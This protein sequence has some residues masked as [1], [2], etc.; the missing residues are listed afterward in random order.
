MKLRHIRAGRELDAQLA[1]M[2]VLHIV[3]GQTLANFTGSYANDGISRG[4]VSGGPIKDFD[5]EQT[6]L[7]KVGAPEQGLFD[8]VPEKAWVALAVAEGSALD[9]PLQLSQNGLI[10]LSERGSCVSGCCARCY[11]PTHT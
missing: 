10:P 3:L 6:L 9:N 4:I 11:R 8:D 2:A 7:E 1:V 5:G